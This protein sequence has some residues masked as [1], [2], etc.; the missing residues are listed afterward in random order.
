MVVVERAADQRSGGARGWG[1]LVDAGPTRQIVERLIREHVVRGGRG[2]RRVTPLPHDP[3]VGDASNLSVGVVKFADE[4][5]PDLDDERPSPH[6]QS[7]RED[8]EPAILQERRR[9]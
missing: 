4:P 9:G 7:G 3:D 5:V 1:A 2:A 8:D 6:G